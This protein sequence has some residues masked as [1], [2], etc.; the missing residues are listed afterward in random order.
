[1]LKLTTANSLF[2]FKVA[3]AIVL[4]TFVGLPRAL[5][6]KSGPFYAD[7]SA[8]TGFVSDSTTSDL[9]VE[10][11]PSLFQHSIGASFGLRLTKNIF[12]GVTTDFRWINQTSDV[13]EGIG[14]RSGSRFNYASLLLG[15]DVSPIIFKLD[16]Q[17]VGDYIYKKRTVYGEEV[18]YTAHNGVRLSALYKI[19]G[20]MHGGVWFETMLFSKE[21]IGEAPAREL[22]PKRELETIGLMI[23]YVL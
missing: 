4:M 22:D 16:I 14:N 20:R 9:A 10:D 1:M 15:L 12:A 23:S 8:G 19:W 5:H 13:K 18:K 6:A 2:L 7:F 17:F 21:E 11:K 3:I